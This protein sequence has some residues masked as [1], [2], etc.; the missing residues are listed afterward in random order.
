[1]ILNDII[2]KRNT[3]PE[4]PSREI[5]GTGIKIQGVDPFEPQYRINCMHMT[6]DDSWLFLSINKVS[7][8]MSNKNE[9]YICAYDL[10]KGKD[11]RPLVQLESCDGTTGIYTCKNPENAT[12]I[13]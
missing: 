13:F 3:V 6:P 11:H 10:S 4:S 7:D 2:A 8:Y 12:E 1:M 9:S 5:C